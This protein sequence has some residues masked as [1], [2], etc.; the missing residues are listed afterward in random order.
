MMERFDHFVG[1][2]TLAPGGREY[3]TIESP[4]NPQHCV[5]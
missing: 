2:A 5:N 3:L 1:G 4:L